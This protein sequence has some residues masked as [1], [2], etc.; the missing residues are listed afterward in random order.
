MWNNKAQSSQSYFCNLWNHKNY[1]GKDFTKVFCSIPLA[2]GRML[3]L[4]LEIAAAG[5]IPSSGNLF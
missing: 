5:S 1:I 2:A 3:N 4:L